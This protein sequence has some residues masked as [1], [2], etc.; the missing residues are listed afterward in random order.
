MVDVVMTPNAA[1]IKKWLESVVDD[2]QARRRV[3]LRGSLELKDRYIVY[4]TA[5]KW[6]SAPGTK[7]NNKWYQRKFGSRYLR[8]D[9]TTGG[10]NTSQNLQTSWQSQLAADDY[11][12]STFTAVTYAPYL[13]DP[14]QRVGWAA[15]HGWQDVNEIAENYAPRLVEIV[16]EEIDK[17]IAKPIV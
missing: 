8:K 15:G 13:Y 5:G 11:F 17:Q 9:G 2:P 1:Q 4:P 7:G 14:A 3:L 10:R 12:I 6:N 16:G